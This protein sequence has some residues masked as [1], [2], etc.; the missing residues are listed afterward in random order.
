MKTS[1]SLVLL[2]AML[3]GIQAQSGKGKCGSDAHFL[4]MLNT[5]PQIKSEWEESYKKLSVGESVDQD[6]QGRIAGM[7]PN[8]TPYDS[9]VP[10]KISVPIVFHIIAP[11]EDHPANISD[12]QI[13]DQLDELN[14][15]FAQE[16][17]SN[18]SLFPSLWYDRYARNTGIRFCLANRDPK[19]NP[20]KGITRRFNE[21][22]S[23]TYQNG[24]AD[25]AM[26]YSNQRGQD[27]WPKEDYLNVWVVVLANNSEA[28]G[29]ATYPIDGYD[30]D[31]YGIVVGYRNFGPGGTAAPPFELGRTLIHE[32]GHY[33]GLM[34]TWGMYENDC[35]YDDLIDDTSEQASPNFSCDMTVT[36]SGGLAPPWTTTC[37]GQRD[38]LQNFMN[39]SADACN[40]FFTQEQASQMKSTLQ[41]GGYWYSLF[42]STK[43]CN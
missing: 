30:E 41:A 36:P 19:G 35:M 23:Y 21:V 38:M 29:W 20:T 27:A 26:K 12:E 1:V 33:L 6:Q 2:F 37:D 14:R 31:E 5:N 18:T 11:T 4:N 32:A 34:H 7:V 40:T 10:E 8:P 24:V 13:L 28:L 42:L 15:A 16:D 25:D 3:A 22:P 17:Y 9:L 43:G 39:A